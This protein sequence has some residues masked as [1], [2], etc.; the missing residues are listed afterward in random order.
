MRAI[1]LTVGDELTGGHTVD[2][3]SCYLAG[4]LAGLGIRVSM[5]ETVGDDVELIARRIAL[6]LD[7]ADLVFI[8][9]GLGPTT[10][11]ITK[12]A[13]ALA[14]GRKMVIDP[15]LKANLE[16]RLK[17]FK[18]AT[19]AVVDLLASVPEGAG[20]LPNRV[21]AAA[22]L[23]IEQAGVRIFVMPG[24]PRE[25]EAVFAD[26]ILPILRRLPRPE[27]TLTRVLKTTGMSESSITRRLKPVIERIEAGLGYLPRPEGVEL[28][29]TAGGARDRVERVLSE[30]T[31][32]IVETLGERVYSTEGE[33]IHFVT[34]RMLIESGLT[35]AVAESCTGGLIGHLLTEVPG[36]SAVLDR[37]VVS[38]SNQAKIDTLG[39]PA[40]LIEKHG[41]VSAEVAE[42]MA[43]G[44]RERAGTDLGLSTTG[45]A[46]PGGGSE[47]KPVG[48]V[49]FGLAGPGLEGL[50]LAAAD[51][52]GDG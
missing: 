48:L 45:I 12:E 28:R 32:I 22:G 40:A 7:G 43:L 1:I 47:E 11:D 9:G 5:L 19:P 21:G 39:V 35:I 51:S 23:V 15:D 27:I 29:I 10:D 52:G 36:I 44:V 13:V 26:E 14:T 30:S 46:G 34:G 17:G 3:N 31:G 25:M 38:Y 6:A 24:V 42:A 37:A 16:A 50:R 4:H 8:T 41:A 2:T 18:S 20:I 49:Y 33:D